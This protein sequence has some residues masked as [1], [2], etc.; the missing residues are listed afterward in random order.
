[1]I[2][3]ETVDIKEL[4]RKIHS[5]AQMKPSLDSFPIKDIEKPYNSMDLFKTDNI[6][7]AQIKEINNFKKTNENLKLNIL[8][9]IKNNTE[10]LDTESLNTESLD[11]ESLDTESLNTESLNTES[12]NTE[13]LD[14]E[15]LNTESLNTESL[16]TESKNN[17]KL[18]RSIMDIKRNTIL[19]KGIILIFI[20]I[21]GILIY[22]GV[23]KNI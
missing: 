19:D 1:M 12:L 20:I 23:H 6:V 21:M 2:K 4:N 3:K 17:N 8:S 15:S 16:N 14:M 13:S 7:G 9:E 5:M 11:T 22:F 18:I 10:S